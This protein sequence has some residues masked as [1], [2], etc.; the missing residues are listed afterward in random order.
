[1][2]WWRKSMPLQG[3][4]VLVTGAA[5]FVGGA[6]TLRLANEGAQVTAFVHTP[7]KAAFLQ[8]KPNIHLVPGDIN[9]AQ[10]VFNVTQ[11]CDVVFHLAAATSGPL[12]HQRK[13]NVEGTRNV[14]EAC[15]RARVQRIV[16]M[17]T[18]AVYG[19]TH[20]EDITE[21]TPIA[22][23]PDPY[24]ISKAE[25]E[26]V[27]RQL[28]LQNDLSYAILRPGFIYGPRSGLWT[29]FMFKLARR[30]P[31]IFIGSGKGAAPAIYIDDLVTLCLLAVTH[32]GADRQAFNATPDP[33]PTWRQFL[34][35]YSRLAGHQT[36]VGIPVW[37]V[38][39]M[40]LIA[41]LFSKQGSMLKYLPDLIDYTNRYI[42]CSNTKAQRL[43]GWHPQVDLETGAQNC[44]PW[45]RK[46]GLLA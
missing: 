36:W 6:L 38:K 15:V 1:M 28:S 37:L 11:G 5:G 34:G 4:S 41:A 18:L 10:G 7:G 9:D 27:L 33:T 19:Y 23:G 2:I 43:L 46:K 42:N 14:V 16:H 32:P 24:A 31:L 22:P 40:S 45:L 8:D 12:D 17:S 25:G 3:K 44:V 35:A 29:G 26:D 21:Q 39:G 20:K 30:K 13:V